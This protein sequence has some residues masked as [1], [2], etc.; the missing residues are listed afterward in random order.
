MP[1]F[2]AARRYMTPKSGGALEVHGFTPLLDDAGEKKSSLWKLDQ[3]PAWWKRYAFLTGQPEAVPEAFKTTRLAGIT[4]EPLLC[5]L[6]TL[7][8]Y[9]TDHWGL[10]AD[11]RNRIYQALVNSI[12]DRGWGEGAAKRQGVGKTLSRSDFNKLME[13]IA[14]AA[15]LG[16]DVRVA[17]EEMFDRCVSIT[18]AQQAWKAFTDD[19]G[20]DVTNLAMNFYLKASERSQRGFEFTHKSFGEYLAARAL[21]SVAAQVS[22]QVPRRI[23]HALED[24]SRAARSGEFNSETL[25]FMNDEVRLLLHATEGGS[26]V[27][28][29]EAIKLAFE[30]L[31]EIVA[32]E[33]F[34]LSRDTSSWK[35]LHTE[36]MN[37]ECGLWLVINSCAK[38]LFSVGEVDK[39]SIEINW[40]T[41][42]GWSD[43]LSRLGNAPRTSIINRCMAHI[44][45][46]KESF[47][48][49]HA[50]ALDLSH[51]N[52]QGATFVACNL[53]AVNF[54]GANLQNGRFYLCNLT[55]SGFRY[56]VADTIIFHKSVADSCVF[57]DAVDNI[58]VSPMGVLLSDGFET[59]RKIAAGRILSLERYSMDTMLDEFGRRLGMMREMRRHQVSNLV[60]DIEFGDEDTPQHLATIDASEV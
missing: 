20:S 13:T 46:P 14:L 21:L 3:R 18:G 53:S 59:S 6:L 37:A 44:T 36:Q 11:N 22:S 33:G 40:P 16:G 29:I 1:A 7:A 26:S 42:D 5:Y 31:A 32:A 38:A 19:N 4:H 58:V 52:L 41:D 60:P 28:K 8:G 34:P 39:S 55:R 2:Q 56:I 9:A 43:L 25:G 50:Y 10:A 23:E 49:L 48:H 54:K 12:Y 17:S 15:W 27:Q 57:D 45:A 24:W 30:Q 35:T 51:A 47:Q